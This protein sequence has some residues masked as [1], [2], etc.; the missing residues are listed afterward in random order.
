MN[1]LQELIDIGRYNI[2][3]L[4]SEQL[5]II[6]TV[7][8]NIYMFENNPIS[9]SQKD[10]TVFLKALKENEI[11][12]ILCEWKT[13]EIDLPSYSFRKALLEKSLSNNNALIILNGEN[14]NE[15]PRG[16]PS[17]T[18]WLPCYT[19]EVSFPKRFACFVL[20]QIQVQLLIFAI[21]FTLVFYIFFY[22]SFILIFSNT[23][24][25]ISVGPKLSSPK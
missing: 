4:E 25:K 13:G 5:V 18:L 19:S 12:Y 22:Y 24:D 17:I 6:K 2:S 20:F 3:N 10:E 7:N 1:E 14:E 8:N 11:K 15:L 9:N 23:S 16:K 21:L